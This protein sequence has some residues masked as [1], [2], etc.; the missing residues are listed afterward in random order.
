MKT[1]KI[2]VLLVVALLSVMMVV[3]NVLPAAAQVAQPLTCTHQGNA[4]PLGTVL[5][6][7]LPSPEPHYFY[8]RCEL[9]VAPW[10]EGARPQWVI[11][12]SNPS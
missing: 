2:R 7:F 5:R 3:G 4:Y 11:Y 1:Q 6:F 12:S 8:M 10:P 9:K